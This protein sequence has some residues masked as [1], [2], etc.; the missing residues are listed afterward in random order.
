MNAFGA[1]RYRSQYSSSC[2]RTSVRSIGN[3][4]SQSAEIRRRGDARIVRRQPPIDREAAH[5]HDAGDLERRAL[6]DQSSLVGPAQVLEL[7]RRCPARRSGPAR[8]IRSARSARVLAGLRRAARR[9]SASPAAPGPI[10][11]TSEYGT[12]RRRRSCRLAS[13]VST[14]VALRPALPRSR[15]KSSSRDHPG[16]VRSTDSTHDRVRSRQHVRVA[17]QDPTR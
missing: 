1:V 5:R 10:A 9:A 14:G 7:E 2:L 3:G 15:S 6:G 17:D 13:Q 8:P 4:G 12:V 16:S 11:V